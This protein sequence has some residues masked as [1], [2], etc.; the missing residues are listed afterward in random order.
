MLERN[1]LRIALLSLMLCG[2]A[3]E[4]D[5]SAERHRIAP[6]LDDV[7]FFERPKLLSKL[8]NGSEPMPEIVFIERDPWKSVIGSDSPKFALYEDGRVIYRDGEEFR[9]IQLGTAELQR[10]RKQLTP[11]H[12]PEFKGGYRIVQATDQPDNILL[13]YRGDPV[14]LDVYGSLDDHEVASYLPD[15]IREAFETLRSFRHA[16]SKR[17]LPQWIEVMV[18]PYEHAVDPSIEWDHDWP[19]LSDQRTIRRGDSYSLFLPSTE[20]EPLRQFLAKAN[21]K[22]AIEIDGRKW[23]A[24][25]RFPFPQEQLWMA[26]NPE[27]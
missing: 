13:F 11:A 8:R 9:T 27:A 18:S 5:R 3:V 14:F 12:R 15:P 23:S 17:W 16:K 20:L 7:R 26:A 19:G 6:V 10:V 21:P 25:I 4:D 22:G 24:S 2:C 1:V